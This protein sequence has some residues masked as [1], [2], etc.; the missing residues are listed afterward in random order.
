MGMD[1]I[2]ID[3]KTSFGANWTGWENLAR[4]LGQLKCDV[5]ELKMENSGFK[6]KQ[7][8]CR[9]WATAILDNLTKGK[10]KNLYVDDKNY[11][12]GGYNQ[13]VFMDYYENNVNLTALLDDD[14]KWLSSFCEFLNVCN[15]CRQY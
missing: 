10:I 7:K 13:L 9:A 15:G 3:K 12:G 4:L 8:T 2:S 11:H 14:I 6:I 5:S 1:L